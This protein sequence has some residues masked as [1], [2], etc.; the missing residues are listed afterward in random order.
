MRI[1]MDSLEILVYVFTV[2]VV[3]VMSYLIGALHGE[4]NGMDKVRK[5]YEKK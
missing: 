1:I 4:L 2:S 3:G 5:I